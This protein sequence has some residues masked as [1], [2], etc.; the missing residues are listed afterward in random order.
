MGIRQKREVEGPKSICETRRRKEETKNFV[1][2]MRRGVGEKEISGAAGT[3]TPPLFTVA[4]ETEGCFIDLVFG[5]SGSL[6]MSDFLIF[7][8]FFTFFCEKLWIL[9]NLLATRFVACARRFK[10]ARAMRELEEP[11]I[12][13]PARRERISSSSSE[14]SEAAEPAGRINFQRGKNFSNY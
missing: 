10:W 9:I 2:K 12:L 13:E 7:C 4:K 11:S 3:P 14:T 1:G 8:Y 6:S 5:P